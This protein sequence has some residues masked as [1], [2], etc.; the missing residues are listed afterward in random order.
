MHSKT[1]F[2]SLLLAAVFAFTCAGT[3]GLTAWAADA[4]GGK[5]AKSRK[6]AADSAKSDGARAEIS[7][8]V[9][10]KPINRD[11]SDRVSYAHIVKRTAASVVYV[12][13]TKTVRGQDMSQLFNDPMFRR[14]F[15]L[16]TTRA[17]LT[18]RR[19][20]RR[21]TAATTTARTPRRAKPP[22]TARRIA[23]S[24]VSARGWS[25]RRT[26]TS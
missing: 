21:A 5:A 25:S 26:A 15:N 9:D 1:S 24:R 3:A 13:S 4:K 22:A 2:S 23:S 18:P 19:R 20:P 11:A 14:F 7:L 6:A 10:A 16:P 8:P 12:Y 17:I